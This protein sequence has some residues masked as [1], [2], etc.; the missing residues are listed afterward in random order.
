MMST[1]GRSFK[2]GGTIRGSQLHGEAIPARLRV[3]EDD[4]GKVIDF[5]TEIANFSPLKN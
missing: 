2:N 3:A 1:I 5:S 4:E